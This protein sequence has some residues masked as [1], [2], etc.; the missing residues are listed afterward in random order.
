MRIAGTATELAD[1]TVTEPHRIRTT[2]RSPEAVWDVV[3]TLSARVERANP[4]VLFLNTSDIVP[5]L[6]GHPRRL[7]ITSQLGRRPGSQQ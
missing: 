1:G 6:F 3:A 5:V 7:N 2:R 4:D